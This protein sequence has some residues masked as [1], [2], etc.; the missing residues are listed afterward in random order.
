MARIS[1]IGA[2]AWGTALANVAARA[3][4]DVVLWA[5]EKEVAAS[6]R[7][8][9]ENRLFLPGVAV[10]APVSA[11]ARLAE[12]GLFGSIVLLVVPAQHVRATAIALSPSLEAD[13][14]VVICAKGIEQGTGALLSEVLAEILPGRPLAVL[15]GPTFAREVAAGL[16]TAVTV[17]ASLSG[18]A[19]HVVSLLSGRTFRGYTS[20]DIAGTEVGGAVKNVIAIAAGIT[21]GLG[22]GENAR[23]A[24]VTRGLAEIVRLGVALGGRPE[25][26]MGLSGLGDLMLTC[27]SASSRNT[28]LG[29]ELAAGRSVQEVLASRRSVAEGVASASSVLQ[30]ARSLGVEMPIVEAVHA[31]VSGAQPPA[32][33]MGRLVDRPFRPEWEQVRG[34]R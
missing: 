28:S 21:T 30:R 29:M 22:L 32:E 26:L 9:R 20:S 11:T 6:I 17:A 31:V 13:V 7:E 12:A 27:L 33:A 5:R 1:V 18:V 2:G 16:P 19:D 10:A 15:S 25:T 34:S 24:L 4:H 23:A 14:P 3:G 8:H